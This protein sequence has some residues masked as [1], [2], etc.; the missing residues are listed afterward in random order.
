M[1]RNRSFR[2]GSSEL[3]LHLSVVAVVLHQGPFRLEP[4]FLLADFIVFAL[5]VVAGPFA[6][7]P[8]RPARSLLNRMLFPIWLISIGSVLGF[9]SFGIS[10]TGVAVIAKNIAPF[11]LIVLIFGLAQDDS[12]LLERV[13]RTWAMVAVIVAGLTL[14]GSDGSL[15]ATGTFENPNYAAHY[16]SVSYVPIFLG[17][18]S[19]LA[20]CAAAIVSLAILATGSFSSFLMLGAMAVYFTY[21]YGRRF[22]GAAKV[23]IRITVC[24]GMLLFFTHAA[25]ALETVEFDA[26]GGLTSSRFARSEESRYELWQ[27]ALAAA[28]SRP[29]GWGPGNS[30]R[31]LS[32]QGG[33]SSGEAHNDV[34]DMLLEGGVIALAG[35][36]I[37]V[38]RLWR[39]ANPGDITR[40]LLFSYVAASTVRQVLNFRH[41]ALLLGLV[42]AHHFLASERASREAAVP[43]YRTGSTVSLG[44]GVGS[45]Q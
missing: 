23:A 8:G 35:L 24:L 15:R 21:S 29:I 2:S 13:F 5:F 36:V 18:R 30:G 10:V 12:A 40:A 33:L 22:A 43:K 1:R 26:G 20:L 32:E 38:R 27:T 9:F 25:T 28:E 3:L 37:A 39:T 7:R 34:L 19:R 44:S 31:A 6:F 42:F 14:A 41:A 11:L 16:L 17:L 4:N 45:V